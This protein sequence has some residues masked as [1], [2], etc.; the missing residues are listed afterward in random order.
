MKQRVLIFLFLVMWLPFSLETIEKEYIIKAAWLQKFARYV[1]WPKE[2]GM[3]DTSK[4]FI[5]GVI[6]E[7]P[8]GGILESSYANRKIK[9]KK[10]VLKFFSSLEQ[11]EECHILFI[12]SSVKKDL[13]EI[14]LKMKQKPVLTV[15]SQKGFAQ[16]GVHINF[17]QSGHKLHFEIN[18]IAIRETSLVIEPSFLGSG[19]IV[20]PGKEENRK[21]K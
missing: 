21:L 20:K 10:V 15:G 6:G 5:I 3:A 11:I 17:Y 12:S 16:N 7:N 4:P 14:L 13:P 1:E 2:S 19:K 9:R 18:P 8:F